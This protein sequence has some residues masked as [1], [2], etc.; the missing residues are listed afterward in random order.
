[1][2]SLRMALPFVPIAA[3]LSASHLS[4][5]LF[6]ASLRRLYIVRDI[7]PAGD[8]ATDKLLT[9]GRAIGI[10]TLPLSPRLGDFNEDLRAFGVGE[11]RAAVRAQIAP[12]D[13][14]RFMA[15][16]RRRAG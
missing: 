11:L 9:R 5:L 3:A 12:E 15:P 7:D 10:E 4:A 2:L 8:R 14:V 6:P 13:V 1:M 16:P